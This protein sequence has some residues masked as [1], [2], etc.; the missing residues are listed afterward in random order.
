MG[1]VVD[2]GW[3]SSPVI[4]F[5]QGQKDLKNDQRYNSII[6]TATVGT[7]YKEEMFISSSRFSEVWSS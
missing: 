6:F 2:N 1:E 7:F 3:N 5:I 4:W